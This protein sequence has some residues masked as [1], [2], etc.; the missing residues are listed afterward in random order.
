MEIPVIPILAMVGLGLF[1]WSNDARGAEA[2]KIIFACCM[3]V[4]LMHVAAA[5]VHIPWW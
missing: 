1:G 4:G 2:G 3:L 5:T